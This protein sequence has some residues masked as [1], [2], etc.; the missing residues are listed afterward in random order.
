MLIKTPDALEQWRYLLPSRRLNLRDAV[1]MSI[2]GVWKV[3]SDVFALE[4]L[5]FCLKGDGE[6]KTLIVY[7]AGEMPA[8]KIVVGATS[9]EPEVFVFNRW[10]CI[11][12]HNHE[13]VRCLIVDVVMGKVRSELQ[14]A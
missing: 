12:L 1:P 13:N 8:F 6:N 4:P 10:I 5:K 3:L 2:P 11:L 7:K 9:S 14:L